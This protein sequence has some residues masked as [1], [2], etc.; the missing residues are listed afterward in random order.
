MDK[1]DA[2]LRALVKGLR[3][4]LDAASP[5]PWSTDTDARIYAED[6]V[7]FD[8]RDWTFHIPTQDADAAVIVAAVNALPVLLDRLEAAEARLSEYENARYYFGSKNE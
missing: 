7:I 2:E 5:R 1:N 8:P 6:E 3:I 4:K